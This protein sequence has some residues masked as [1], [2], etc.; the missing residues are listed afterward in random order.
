LTDLTRSKNDNELIAIRRQL[1]YPDTLTE[2]EIDHMITRAGGIDYIL[3]PAGWQCL[4]SLLRV[5]GKRVGEICSILLSDIKVD[6]EFLSVTFTVE[7]K[8][9]QIPN[10]DKVKY[11]PNRYTKR[12][13]LTNPY[14]ENY[15]LPYL[16]RDRRKGEKFLFP[17]PRKDRSIYPKYVWD[18]IRKMGF[19]Q[20]I[21][22]HLFRHTL[23][24]ELAM[25]N[26]TP[27]ELKSWF[28]WES[29]VLADKYVSR[30][31]ITTDKISRRR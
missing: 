11:L 6:E 27:F 28:D 5:Y 31:G 29:I 8:I 26:F 23:A 4:F 22:S 25:E 14:V 24:T 16:S 7:K 10:S 21:W 13:S 15:I 18:A 2:D 9:R 1:G 19:R 30:A 17:C 12:I 3:P 20:P